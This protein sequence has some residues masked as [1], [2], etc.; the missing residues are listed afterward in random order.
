MYSNC[1]IDRLRKLK[2]WKLWRNHLQDPVNIFGIAWGLLWRYCK[3]FWLDSSN[4]KGSDFKLLEVWTKRR[5]P[6]APW[7]IIHQSQL[8]QNASRGELRESIAS[9][10]HA[11][12]ID[13]LSYM[14]HLFY[15]W[16]WLTMCYRKVWLD[17]RTSMIWNGWPGKNVLWLL[18]D[19]SIQ[20]RQGASTSRKLFFKDHSPKVA[21]HLCGTKPFSSPSYDSYVEK[22]CRKP[23]VQ[24]LRIDRSSPFDKAIIAPKLVV[25]PTIK[26]NKPTQSPAATRMFFSFGNAKNIFGIAT[27]APRAVSSWYRLKP[28]TVFCPGKKSWRKLEDSPTQL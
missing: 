25:H 5:H 20:A 23:P 16:Q 11:E 15:I 28:S 19:L 26:V 22:S 17:G 2:T 4:P 6:T 21:Q 3:W 12:E 10:P 13:L 8:A 1:Q 14:L 24:T 7:L 9:V 27:W 18:Q